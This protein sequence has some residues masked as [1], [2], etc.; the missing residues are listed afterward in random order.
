MTR[1]CGADRVGDG[2]DAEDGGGGDFDVAGLFGGGLGGGWDEVEAD[3]VAGRLVVEAVELEAVAES[4]VLGGAGRRAQGG[5][6]SECRQSERGAEDG[7]RFHQ[8][9]RN[10]PTTGVPGLDR[11]MRTGRFGDCGMRESV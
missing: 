10:H 5:E 8:R 1:G 6:D 9:Y 11:G 4:D 2:L 7:V 3:S